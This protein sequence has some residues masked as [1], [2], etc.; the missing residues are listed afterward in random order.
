MA[1]DTPNSRTSGLATYDDAFMFNG[2]PER[3]EWNLVGKKEMIVPYHNYDLNYHLPKE[4]TTGGKFINPD[5]MRWEKHRVWELE[6]TL[7]QDLRHVYGKRTLYFDE[8]TLAA[9]VSDPYDT[10]GDLWRTLQS[11]APVNYV[12]GTGFVGAI[13]GYDFNKCIY[14]MSGYSAESTIVVFDADAPQEPSSF[15]SSSGL[16][17]GVFA[18][19]TSYCRR[20]EPVAEPIKPSLRRLFG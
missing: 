10:R 13:A 14:Y 2:S 3:Y 17:R 9:V 7:K 19:Q 15:Y 8:Y 11:I 5:H 18:N 4:K 1:F 16:A 6:G 12:L 20:H